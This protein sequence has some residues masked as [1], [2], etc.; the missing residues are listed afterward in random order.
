MYLVILLRNFSVKQFEQLNEHVK[1]LTMLMIIHYNEQ[2][3]IPEQVSWI[4][5]RTLCRE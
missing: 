2:T 4:L 3:L 1:R 5:S